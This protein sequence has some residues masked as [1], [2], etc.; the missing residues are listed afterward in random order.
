M[1]DC[2]WNSLPDAHKHIFEKKKKKLFSVLLSKHAFKGE[3]ISHLL[4][5]TYFWKSAR[6]FKLEKFESRKNFFLGLYISIHKFVLESR[7][8]VWT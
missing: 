7:T 4:L 5:S 6:K 2:P 3:T 1:F 8:L